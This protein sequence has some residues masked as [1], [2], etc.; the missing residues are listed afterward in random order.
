[1]RNFFKCGTLSWTT[2]GYNLLK[3]NGC[4]LGG[5][6]LICILVRLRVQNL[7]YRNP[8]WGLSSLRPPNQNIY[9]KRNYIPAYLTLFCYYFFDWKAAKMFH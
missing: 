1:M 2:Q 9:D 6:N 5:A 3:D 4:A 8:C 7:N